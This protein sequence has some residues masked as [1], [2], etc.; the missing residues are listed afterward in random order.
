M[1][2]PGSNQQNELV[3]EKHVDAVYLA[4]PA[5]QQVRDLTA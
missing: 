3:S 2:A 5:V 1:L 4:R